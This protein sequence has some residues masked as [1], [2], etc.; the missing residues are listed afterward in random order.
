[1]DPKFDLYCIK[2]VINSHVLINIT[3]FRDT[4]HE[5]LEV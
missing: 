3:L 1:M 2:K 5:I 4:C